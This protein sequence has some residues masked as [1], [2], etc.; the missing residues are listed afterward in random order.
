MRSYPKSILAA[1]AVWASQSVYPQATFAIS[2]AGPMTTSTSM[3]G[4]GCL[5]L[6]A[7]NVPASVM[8]AWTLES[9]EGTLTASSGTTTVYC[10][11]ARG[12]VQVRA[13]ASSGAK[14]DVTIHVTAPSGGLFQRLIAGIEG[15]GGAATQPTG[16][17][18][19]DMLLSTPISN[20]GHPVFGPNLR[21]WVD[22]RITSVP[23]QFD[24]KV[25]DFSIANAVKD[26]KVNEIAQVI[27][28]MG[29]PQYR[30]WA[31]DRPLKAF[32]DNRLSR[33]TVSLIA[34]YG[35]T[36]PIVPKDFISTFKMPAKDTDAYDRLRRQFGSELDR[37]PNATHVS[38]VP[39]DRQ[40]FWR[41]YYAGLRIQS[42]FYQWN[43][44]PS[45][46]PMRTVDLL[47]GQ[48]ETVTGGR[49]RGSVVRIDFF[50][51]IAD[52]TSGVT[53]YVF[54]TASFKP[55]VERGANAEA[56]VLNPLPESERSS[57]NL[58]APTTLLL[59][60]PPSNRDFFRI[61]VGIDLKRV[62]GN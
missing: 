47:F 15:S 44:A 46:V 55:S 38:F 50:Q 45:S 10:P 35:G 4:G 28:V 1:V 18:F 52:F 42:H 51:P 58:T 53:I 8:V 29:G 37:R 7:T 6:L 31:Q 19:F 30:L 61:G 41:Q 9:G 16:R 48:N 60:A 39:G 21:L 23:R 59:T 26:L 54:G 49:W 12:E 11:G 2:P 34:A 36:T 14:S 43:G 25:T 40:R 13:T 62:F 24:V 56:L 17:I 20:G 57:F 33:T 22:S 3:P 5:A 32:F 27:E